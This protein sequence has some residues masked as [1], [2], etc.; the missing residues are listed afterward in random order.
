[1]VFDRVMQQRRAHHISVADPV[2]ADDPDRHPQHVVHIRLALAPV[3]G[4]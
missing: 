3:G 1:M 4:M 2:M